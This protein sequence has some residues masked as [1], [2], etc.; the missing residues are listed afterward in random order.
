MSFFDNKF[1]SFFLFV[2]IF[3]QGHGKYAEFYRA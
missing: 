2:V 1:D 3:T